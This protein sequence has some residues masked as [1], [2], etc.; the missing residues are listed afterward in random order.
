MAAGIQKIQD[1]TNKVS[2]KN[3][4]KLEAPGGS[5]QDGMDFK[6]S[7][8]AQIEQLQKSG[9]LATKGLGK[10]SLSDKIAQRATNLSADLN[11]DHQHVSKMLERATQ[12]GD[13]NMLLKAML[14]LNDYQVRVQFVS[15]TIS[16]AANSF[17]Q[18]T[19]LQ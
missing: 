4:L 16:K 19:R 17:D 7:L 14:A 10:D 5:V 1:V 18:L 8:Q 9:G 13:Q 12:T 11:K 2:E 6:A 3:S 15:K